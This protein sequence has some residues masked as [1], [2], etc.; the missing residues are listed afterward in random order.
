MGCG[1]STLLL[2]DLYNV[3]E[4]NSLVFTGS[5]FPV[6]HSRIAG[7]R[8]AI[9]ARELDDFNMAVS[10]TP[11]YIKYIFVDEC[12]F[13]T[14]NAAKWLCRLADIDGINLRFYG[15]LSDFRGEMFP[16]VSTVLP[17][18]NEHTP[19]PGLIPCSCGGHGSIN[20]RVVKGRVQTHGS[21]ILEGDIRESDVYY[22][23]M[24]RKCWRER[25]ARDAVP[26]FDD[27]PAKW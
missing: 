5:E 24:C 9:H 12:Q 18:A 7:D 20:A 4:A 26:S 25:A 27:V 16:G 1:K 14:V 6:I 13:V 8:D 15:L 22:Q 17:L 11:K 23:V 10:D 3:G 19:L 21:Q 2:Q